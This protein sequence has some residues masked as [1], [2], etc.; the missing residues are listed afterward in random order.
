MKFYT[1]TP[2]DKRDE[3]NVYM[4]M[5]AALSVVAYDYIEL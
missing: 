5:K 4:Y 2:N 3:S 1:S